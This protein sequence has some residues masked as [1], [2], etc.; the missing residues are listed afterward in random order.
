MRG[1]DD[2]QEALFS[3][4]SMERRIPDDHPLRA[5]RVLVDEVL[6]RLGPDF[7]E[8]YSSTGRPSIP[9]EQLLRGLLL[10]MVNTIR[11]ERQLVEQIDYNLL[12]RWFVGLQMD[13]DVWSP[14]TFSK[15]R[16]RLLSAEIAKRFFQEVLILAS[17]RRLMSGEHFTVDGT[18]VEAWASLKSFQRKGTKPRKDHDDPGNPTVN[19]HG[20]KRSNKTHESTTDP[21]SQLYRK[22]NSQAAR[23]CFA[24]HVLMENRNGLAVNAELTK[25]TGRAERETAIKMLDELPHKRKRVTLGADKGYDTRQMVHDLRERNVTPHLAKNDFM[26]SPLDGR[27]MRHEGYKRSQ[28]TRKKVEEIFGWLKNIGLMR[29]PMLR[30]L[31]RVGPMF[32][33]SVALYNLIR[34]RN[35]SYG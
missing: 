10:Q 24:G 5:L 8:L 20:E 26:R 21:D 12:Y 1:A 22:G 14:T 32:T 27:T 29:R 17:R 33:F 35:L 11:S 2:S 28:R 16:D 18:L 4:V 15:N 6:E 31:N 25:A 9:P 23:L 13:D 30:G 7:E 3:Y 34:I 19:F